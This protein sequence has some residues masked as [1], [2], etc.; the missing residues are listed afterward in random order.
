M[1][2]ALSTTTGRRRRFS[3][4][5]NAA[6]WRWAVQTAT[7]V[8]DGR[9]AAA[10]SPRV[11]NLLLRGLCRGGGRAPDRGGAP[12]ASAKLAAFKSAGLVEGVEGAVDLAG[13]LLRLK[14]SLTCV[15]VTPSG[16][17][18]AMS[19]ISSAVGSPSARPGR[20]AIH[21]GQCPTLGQGRLAR[22]AGGDVCEAM[23]RARRPTRAE[24]SC[25]RGLPPMWSPRDSSVST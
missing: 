25:V 8:P 19:Q 23:P 6:L 18:F 5:T 20:G 17:S 12:D 15:R 10:V 16:C 3:S 4:S 1:T 13:L 2:N 7:T 24:T 9:T 11:L 22:I 14:R 21:S